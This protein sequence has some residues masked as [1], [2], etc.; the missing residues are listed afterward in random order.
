[1]S[2]HSGG[3]LKILL[4]IIGVIVVLLAAGIFVYA[5]GI[6]AADSKDDTSVTVT[7]PQG[8]GAS[9]I[10]DILDE[11]L[12]EAGLWQRYMRVS[13]VMI[14]CRPTHIYSADR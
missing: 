9:S 7:I 13:E 5:G 6:G 8:S 11:N 2:R 14:H 12:S 1:M 3:R 10:V 4:I